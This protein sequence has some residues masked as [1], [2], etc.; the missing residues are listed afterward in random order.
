[1]SFIKNFMDINRALEY[2]ESDC[3]QK[4]TE[5]GHLLKKHNFIKKSAAYAASVLGALFLFDLFAFNKSVRR[6]LLDTQERRYYQ[7]KQG[8]IFYSVSGEGD[9]V[10][11]IHG[12]EDGE[13]GFEWRKTAENLA[14]SHK[15]YIPDL[16]GYGR[17]TKKV[18]QYTNY[19]F[20][21]V[22]RDFILDVIGED[23]TV[24]TAGKSSSAAIAAAVLSLPQESDF[25]DENKAPYV[26]KLILV[27]PES[28]DSM[29]ENTSLKDRIY[30]ALLRLPIIGTTLYHFKNSYV[31]LEDRYRDVG[32][33]R[34]AAYFCESAHLGG[35]GARYISASNIGNYTQQNIVGLLKKLDI[36]VIIMGNEFEEGYM[37]FKSDAS[38][39]AITCESGMPQIDRPDELSVRIEEALL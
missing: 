13:A 3:S 37:H 7:W 12:L 1:M 21:D 17:S 14:Q 31:V 36:P 16:P 8:E 30:S 29:T 28:L 9:P 27:E 33:R 24:I 34:I 26:K 6:R 18:S 15:V 32:E 19:V 23:T 39:K 35:F 25:E 20:A 4:L 22:I 5:R 38:F 10:L 2:N 11:L